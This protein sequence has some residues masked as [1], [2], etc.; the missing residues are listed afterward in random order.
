[1][2]LHES[3]KSQ[4]EILKKD[5]FSVFTYIRFEAEELQNKNYTQKII[6]LLDPSHYIQ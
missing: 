5:N 6:I 2:N 1:M 3:T 4:T